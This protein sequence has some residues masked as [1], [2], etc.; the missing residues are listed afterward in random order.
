MDYRQKIKKLLALAESPNENE[1]R[2]AL[3]KAR[4]LMA[5]HHLSEEDCVGEG[6]QKI[7]R[8]KTAFSCTKMVN[9]W[10]IP[11]SGVI[12]TAYRCLPMTSRFHGAKTYGI[13]MIGFEEDVSLCHE[14]FAYAVRFVEDRNKKMAAEMGKIGAPAKYIRQLKNSYGYGFTIGLQ[15]AIEL[16]NG[17]KKQEW[18]LV[19][20]TPNEVKESV[21]DMGSLTFESNA[22]KEVSRSD[23]LE[24]YKDGREFNTRSVLRAG[25]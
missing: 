11:L 5:E 22:E 7:V 19:L 24:G 14:L 13:G 6:S 16:Q 23:Y 4:E 12:C 15:E 18:G 1:A 20:V 9:P 17:A 2:V 3:L 10:M 25:A 21:S 8:F